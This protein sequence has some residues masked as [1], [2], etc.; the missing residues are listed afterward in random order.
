MRVVIGVRSEKWQFTEI[1]PLAEHVPIHLAMG[2][3]DGS[4]AI[5]AKDLTVI[6]AL[7][8]LREALNSAAARD[9]EVGGSIFEYLIQAPEEWLRRTAPVGSS[10]AI[11]CYRVS[12][13]PIF[14]AD[15]LNERLK[16]NPP[17]D[18]DTIL[19]YI[20]ARALIQ[21]SAT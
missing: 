12:E 3:A 4:V 15:K 11:D 1:F 18:F 20:T 14:E 17:A 7:P 16:A 10:V 6:D 21:Q 8:V 2:K 5:P 13:W 9:P 19:G